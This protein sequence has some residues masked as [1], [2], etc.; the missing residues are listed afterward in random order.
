MI[1]TI[2]TCAITTVVG[3]LVGA[4]IQKMLSKTNKAIQNE[5]AERKA[6]L[7]LLRHEIVNVYVAYKDIKEIPFFLKESTLI[8][9]EVYKALGGNS[10]IEQIIAELK[11]WKVVD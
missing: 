8:I 9:Y 7:A 10:F 11:Q 4:F 2:V 1:L 5:K 3:A 6:I